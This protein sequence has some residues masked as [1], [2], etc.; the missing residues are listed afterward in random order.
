MKIFDSLVKSIMLYAAEVWGWKEEEK[1]EK[2]QVKFIK[3]T[4]RLDFNTPTYIVLEE[5][6]TDKIRIEAGRRA[7]RYEEKGR[8]KGV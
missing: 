3:W 1:L 7:V 6:K 4:L 5:T 2:L 8:T